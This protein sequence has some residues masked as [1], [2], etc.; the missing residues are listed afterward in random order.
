MP[1][2]LSSIGDRYNEV[3]CTCIGIDFV[4]VL[5]TLSYTTRYSIVLNNKIL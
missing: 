2:G 1:S 3:H 4:L 5:I